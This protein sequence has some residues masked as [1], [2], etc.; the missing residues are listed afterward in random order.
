MHRLEEHITRV[1]EKADIQ[2]SKLQ[3]RLERVSEDVTQRTETTM[4]LTEEN[5]E[6]LVKKQGDAVMEAMQEAFQEENAS[7]QNHIDRLIVGDATAEAPQQAEHVIGLL[8]KFDERLDKGVSSHTQCEHWRELAEAVKAQKKEV[9][10]VLGQTK[11]ENQGLQDNVQ[12]LEGQVAMLEGNLE[13]AREQ[14]SK[15]VIWSTLIE[16]LDEIHAHKNVTMSLHTG[17]IDVLTGMNFEPRKPSEPPDAIFTSQEL[18]DDVLSDLVVLLSAFKG[19]PVCI[20]SHIKPAKGPPAFW[21]KVTTA[22]AELVK[23]SLQELGVDISLV[24]TKGLVGNK[25]LNKNQMRL[26]VDIFPEPPAED[27]KGGKGRSASPSASP[28]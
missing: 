6:A 7:L 4:R 3:A 1:D 22:R 27:K 23:T 19:V 12:T 20:E 2:E 28:R 24:T 5:V 18:A 8:R 13:I 21:Q 26:K 15:P 10:E 9:D 25:G 17:E 16:I 11:D 14:L